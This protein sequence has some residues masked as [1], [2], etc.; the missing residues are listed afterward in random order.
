[1]KGKLKPLYA[2]AFHLVDCEDDW[3]MHLVEDTEGKAVTFNTLTEARRRLKKERDQYC[4]DYDIS[5][6]ADGKD[7]VRKEIGRDS[8]SFVVPVYDVE[9]DCESALRVSAKIIKV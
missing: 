2:I 7:H 1:M 6:S 5:W 8:F 4:D 3:G 9:N